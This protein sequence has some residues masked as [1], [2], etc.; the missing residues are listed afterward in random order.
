MIKSKFTEGQICEFIYLKDVFIDEEFMVFEDKG[1]NRYLIPA[2]YYRSYRLKQGTYIKCM[3]SRVDCAGKVSFEPEHPYYKVGGTYDFDF[4]KM[5]VTEEA[6]YDPNTEKSII[7]NDYH[8]IVSDRDGNH[9]TVTPRLWQRKIR[10]R[11][12]TIKCRLI[13]IIKGRFQLI[14]LE[15]PKPF[16]NKMLNIIINKINPELE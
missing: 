7:T 4:V 11:T 2:Q 13:K 8:I 6:E 9:H 15:E 14:N 16:L 3:V 5:Q 10:Y 12:E 1:G